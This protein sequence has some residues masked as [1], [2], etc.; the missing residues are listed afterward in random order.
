[1]VLFGQTSGSPWEEQLVK[2]KSLQWSFSLT[3]PNAQRA[4]VQRG[5]TLL[6]QEKTQPF[7]FL[8]LAVFGAGILRCHAVV[9]S[10]R[11]AFTLLIVSG[12][13]RQNEKQQR[14]LRFQFTWVMSSSGNSEVGGVLNES[15]WNQMHVSTQKSTH[16][17]TSA[18]DNVSRS[19]WIRS[20]I[21]FRAF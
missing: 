12:A 17:S 1:M 15:G 20:L 13:G 8:L 14:L 5:Q 19:L 9:Q 6:V 16:V 4:S 11:P 7:P 21:L 10:R 2:N 18:V 3:L